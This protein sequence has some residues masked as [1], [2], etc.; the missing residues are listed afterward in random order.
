MAQ[1]ADA[2][3]ILPFEDGY[4]YLRHKLDVLR[5]HCDEIGRPYD[6]I[7]KTGLL[8]LSVA[9]AVARESA[10]DQLRNMARIGFDGVQVDLV[11]IHE[12]GAIDALGEVAEAVRDVVPAGR[13]VPVAA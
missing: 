6:E 4:D 1:Y 10:I 11:E 2:C 12:P 13:D 9:D 3:N 8:R 7:V 5:R